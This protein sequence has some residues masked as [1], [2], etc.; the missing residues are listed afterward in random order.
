[1]N[2]R[3]TLIA[4]LSVIMIILMTAFLLRR[5]LP[6]SPAR[7]IG[8]PEGFAHLLVAEIRMYHGKAI[9]H[10]F[11]ESTIYRRFRDD[12]D[13]SRQMFLKRFPSSEAAFYS[14]LV[15]VLARGQGDRLGADYPH[16]RL[17]S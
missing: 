4:T 7:Q 2:D 5:I 3:I 6:H 8:S 15:A 9:D 13:R 16:P 11:D 1:V 14:A 10:A 17:V 12:I